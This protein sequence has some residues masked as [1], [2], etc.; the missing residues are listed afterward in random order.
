[1]SELSTADIRKAISSRLL[2]V[3]T[4][5]P[6]KVV[7]Y[8]SATQTASVAPAVRAPIPKGRD[9]WEK[10]EM[11]TIPNVPVSWPAGG[12][13]SLQLGLQQGDPVLLIFCE[14][15]TSEYRNT[16]DISDPSDL[17]RH[18]GSYPYAIPGGQ[19]DGTPLRNVSAPHIDPGSKVLNV[20][21]DPGS[22]DFVALAQLV[23]D[24][25]T[26][27]SEELTELKTAIGAG[28]TAVGVG[29]AANGPSG[30]TAF[31]GASATIP[32]S[33]NTVAASK[34]KTE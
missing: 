26:R 10:V 5:L 6:G 16:G 20:G 21:G 30:K 19:P 28:F 18:D 13:A 34:L 33:T 23:A 25:F 1:M 3:H 8:D 15:D 31:D 32:G 7:S 17:T 24:E 14:A 12:G 2:D 29:T 11:P 9:G 27:V 22:M 4:A